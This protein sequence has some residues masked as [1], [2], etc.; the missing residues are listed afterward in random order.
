MWARAS[1]FR[2]FTDTNVGLCGTGSVKVWTTRHKIP[3]YIRIFLQCKKYWQYVTRVRG[4]VTSRGYG[5]VT[6]ERL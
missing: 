5:N 6:K 2:R 3:A 4:A 1:L